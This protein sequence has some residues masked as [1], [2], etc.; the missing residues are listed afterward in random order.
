MADG[1]FFR[2]ECEPYPE[3]GFSSGVLDEGCAWCAAADAGVERCLPCAELPNGVRNCA[4]GPR[5]PLRCEQMA[6]EFVTP[7]SWEGDS[8]AAPIVSEGA[9]DA[10]H[11]RYFGL[12]TKHRHGV[13]RVQAHGSDGGIFLSA[14]RH[15]P[16]LASGSPLNTADGAAWELSLIHI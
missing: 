2:Y 15:R 12:S 13:L 6:W 4:F 10:G 16:G 8:F 5:P 7:L 14:T 9:L 3:G 1:L 11:A